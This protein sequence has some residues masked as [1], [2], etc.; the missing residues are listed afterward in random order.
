MTTTLR[1]TR[2]KPTKEHFLAILGLIDEASTWLP[3]KGTNQ[4]SKPWP[5][6]EDRDARVLRGLEV[7]ATW[8]VWAGNRAVATVT[9]AN[10]PN[11]A[12][13]SE[14]ECDLSERAVYVHR[15]IVARD[16]AGWGLGAELL[17][18]A[19]LRGR[20]RYGAR[21]IRI[22]VWT[23]NKALHDYYM[24]RGFRPCGM[25]PDPSYPSGQLFQKSVSEISEPRRPQF[26][27]PESDLELSA[28]VNY[29]RPN[30]AMSHAAPAPGI[31][32]RIQDDPDSC[33]REDPAVADGLL[34][35][36][37]G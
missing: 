2:A 10:G 12:V 18:W 20:R 3:A 27:D 13:W 33:P 35:S 1:I 11:N 8:I 17:D 22:D 32:P 31:R 28:A 6:R 16:Y 23:S 4:W 24:K 19:G 36:V 15:L 5:T 7:G 26:E 25:C 34:L 21:W 14:S 9:I 37:R 30:R 29:R